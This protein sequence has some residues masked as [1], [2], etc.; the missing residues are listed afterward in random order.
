MTPNFQTIFQKLISQII[1]TQEFL[2]HLISLL[3]FY[4]RVFSGGMFILRVA[5][6]SVDIHVCTHLNIDNNRIYVTF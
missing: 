1:N 3:K 6:P 2:H 5:A 4:F